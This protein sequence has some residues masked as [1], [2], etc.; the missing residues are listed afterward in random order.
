MQSVL[1][2]MPD[3]IPEVPRDGASQQ[4][5][6]LTEQGRGEFEN[7]YEQ[8]LNQNSKPVESRQQDKGGNESQNQRQPLDGE[9]SAK[10]ATD[11]LD[12][13]TVK[14]LINDKFVVEKQAVEGV[15]LKTIVADSEQSVKSEGQQPAKSFDQLLDV[16]HKANNMLRQK[17]GV[18]SDDG[19]QILRQNKLTAAIDEALVSHDSKASPGKEMLE[20]LMAQGP[21]D[22]KAQALKNG[23][24]LTPP[25][26]VKPSGGKVLTLDDLQTPGINPKLQIEMA[27]Q[28]GTKA[29]V[30]E[31]GQVNNPFLQSAGIKPAK[32]SKDELPQ[33]NVQQPN[34]QAGKGKPT[35]D[36]MQTPGIAG[37]P[38]DA[39]EEV[40]SQSTSSTGTANN[41]GKMDKNNL[42][43]FETPGINPNVELTSQKG[44]LKSDN[45]PVNE[46]PNIQT[47]LGLT[48]RPF[49]MAGTKQDAGSIK[50]INMNETPGIV[51][52]SEDDLAE[53]G[54]KITRPMELDPKYAKAFGQGA[55]L[56]PKNIDNQP[57]ATQTQAVQQQTRPKVDKADPVS[58]SS[59]SG[60]KKESKNILGTESKTTAK[61]KGT[62]NTDS[63]I[64]ADSTKLNPEQQLSEKKL[65]ESLMAQ[66]KPEQQ[67]QVMEDTLS[68]MMPKE[69]NS[70][71]F[72]KAFGQF[73]N[74]NSIFAADNSI[75]PTSSLA[76][77]TFD[78]K[79]TAQLNTAL[80]MARP[81]FSNNM[82]ERLTVMMNKGIQ[83]ADIRL[84]PAELGQMQV[85]MSVEND[86][87]SVS[88]IVQSSQAKEM[89]EQ[90][91]P[92]LKEMLAEQGIEM[93]EGSVDQ[94]DKS[95][96]ELG[97]G[98]HQGRG[99]LASEN[100]D[101][102][103]EIDPLAHQQVKITN[104]ALGGIDFFA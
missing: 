1:K 8:Q 90:A 41:T 96:Q 69:L 63:V 5:S 30:K 7:V 93:G 99:Q 37:V 49:E 45:A 91:M 68:R 20:K 3:P 23:I 24:Q 18:A 25:G 11:K 101:N 84:D 102:G 57:V 83:T 89:L 14:T 71:L 66:H 94:E 50:D 19:E 46:K 104:G 48:T 87:T 12:T 42:D 32:P 52:P 4:S 51:P 47:H 88:F 78:A 73:N 103:D 64:T 82:K 56:Q 15:K 74:P 16:M 61:G 38:D 43:R 6:G 58:F 79:T 98:Q 97:D 54:A 31:E 65:M 39:G 80:N 55:E 22:G 59:L 2:L 77:K 60:D 81:D 35:L 21:N 75:A 92:K 76:A 100:E 67:T 85:K 10:S 33:I 70:G 44:G 34:A 28:V 62:V 13:T 40:L 27:Q 29:G 72:N 36:E 86:V 9:A 53:Q 26:E 17:N 95:Q